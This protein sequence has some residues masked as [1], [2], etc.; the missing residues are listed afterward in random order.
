M[1]GDGH[2]VIFLHGFL[3]SIT[4]WSQLD[5]ESLPFKSVLIDL[6]GHGLSPLTDDSSIPSLDYYA[7][8]VKKILVELHISNYHA[9]GHSMGGYVALKL[10]EFDSCCKKVVLLNSNF[11]EDEPGKK[12]DRVR[13]ADVAL[14]AKSLFVNEAI[15]GLFYRHNR[16]NAFIKD[17]TTEAKKIDGVA[18]AYASLAMRN[19]SNKRELLLANPNDFLIIQGENDPLISPKKMQR[20]LINSNVELL[21]FHQSGHMAHYEEPKRVIKTLSEFLK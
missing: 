19:R 9:V 12:R 1:A 16:T 15:P 10:K 11:W 14:K 17:L 7:Q 3:E 21:L 4:M 18:I 5:L 8:E 20:E 6:P 2:P 13:V